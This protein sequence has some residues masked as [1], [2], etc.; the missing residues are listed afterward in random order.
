MVL[1]THRGPVLGSTIQMSI[2]RV[3]FSLSYAGKKEEYQ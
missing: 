1:G 3:T 2:L